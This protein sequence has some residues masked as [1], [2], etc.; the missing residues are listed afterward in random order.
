MLYEERTLPKKSKLSKY[1]YIYKYGNH[2]KNLFLFFFLEITQILLKNLWKQ[3]KQES[4]RKKKSML[5]VKAL[6]PVK[7]FLYIILRS[8]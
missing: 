1:N 6:K 4:T 3:I 8:E 5:K 7:E 2:K